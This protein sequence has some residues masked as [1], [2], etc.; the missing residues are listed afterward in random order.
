MNLAKNINQLQSADKKLAL[1]KAE[2]NQLLRAIGRELRQLRKNKRLKAVTVAKAL[3]AKPPHLFN[4]EM[5]IAKMTVEKLKKIYKVVSTLNPPKT[6]IRWRKAR[7]DKVD[8]RKSTS[9]IAKELGVSFEAVRLA[10]KKY[11]K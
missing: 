4:I 3:K 1:A 7:W 9:Q 6:K 2:R 5:G 11:D 8:W 10:R